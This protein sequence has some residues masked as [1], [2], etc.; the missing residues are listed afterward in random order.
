MYYDCNDCEHEPGDCLFC[1]DVVKN[2]FKPKQ[3][4]ENTEETETMIDNHYLDERGKE[5]E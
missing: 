5:N 4:H 1:S 2:M 3:P